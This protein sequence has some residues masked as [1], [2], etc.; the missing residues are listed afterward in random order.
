MAQTITL[1][2]D[3]RLVVYTDNGTIQPNNEQSTV[4]KGVFEV[5][6][7]DVVKLGV[8]LNDASFKQ[9]FQTFFG[10]YIVPFSTNGSFT[11]VSKDKAIEDCKKYNEKIKSQY[12]KS[13]EV[14]D[15]LNKQL[16]RLKSRNIFER[17]FRKYE[18]EL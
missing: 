3:N 13:Q 7:S 17:I 2:D 14:V 12:D 15:K 1:T 4:I 8:L 6:A 18:E 11:I 16:V 10:N 9:E 5:N